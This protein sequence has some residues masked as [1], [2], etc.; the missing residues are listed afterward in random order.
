MKQ[1]PLTQVVTDLN[2]DGAI[3]LRQQVGLT[4]ICILSMFTKNCFFSHIYQKL[5]SDDIKEK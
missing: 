5:F 1:P 2:D 4:V 3:P